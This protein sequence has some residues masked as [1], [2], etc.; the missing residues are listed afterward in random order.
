MKQIIYFSLAA[1]LLLFAYVVFRIIVRRSYIERGQ[2]STLSSSLQLLV[3][4]GFFWFPYLY[5]PPEW[6]WFWIANPSIPLGLHTFGLLL[7][8][9]GILGAFGIMGWFGIKRAFGITNDRLKKTGPYRFSR[10]PQILGGY[11]LVLGTTFQWLSLYMVGW[12]AIYAIIAH[13]M[14]LTEEEHLRRIFGEEY[15]KYCSEV[16]RYLLSRKKKNKMVSK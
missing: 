11:L 16:P 14:I 6:G 7:V 2:L 10:N 1:L 4:L 8:C 13:W 5:N 3:F 12:L 9:I 15:V